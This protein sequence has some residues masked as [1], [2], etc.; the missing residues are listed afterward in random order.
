MPRGLN[1]T[2]L[3]LLSKKSPSVMGDLRSIALCNVSYKI[4]S[5]VMA[6]RLKNRRSSR[7]FRVRLFLMG[8][9]E[10]WVDMIMECRRTIS[11]N[12]VH[13]GESLGPIVP[14]RGN[15]QGDPMSTY[16]FIICVEGLFALIR[17]QSGKRLSMSRSSLI[18]LKGHRAR[19]TRESILSTLHM[20]AADYHS[21]YLGL[22]SMVGRNKSVTFDFV[23]EK[24]RKRIHNWDSKLLSRVGKEVLMKLVI[25]SLLT[26]AMSVYFDPVRNLRR[27]GSTY[28]VNN[29]LKVDSLEWDEEVLQDLFV[30]RD[31]DLIH[32]IPL[33]P[34]S[35]ED[36]WFWMFK[37]YGDY[38][39][40][41]AYRAL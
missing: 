9:T 11:Y 35:V 4:I 33:S 13:G 29:L 1:A 24:V 19:R 25:Q 8:F 15:R 21:F 28:G 34:F 14:S 36:T 2:N 22:P 10:A 16:L 26:C 31:V 40:K 39:V 37:T 5:K 3:V 27:C 38:S 41:S 6:N 20:R 12:I 7:S 32:R 23:K 30:Q 17:L 18:L